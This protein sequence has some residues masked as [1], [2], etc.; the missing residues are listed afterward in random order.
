MALSNEERIREMARL[1]GIPLVP[2]EVAEVG[3]RLDALLD[4]LELLRELDLEGVE[5]LI[6]VPDQEEP[7]GRG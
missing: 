4:A 2:E 3:H 6:L 5:P 1:A 7:G